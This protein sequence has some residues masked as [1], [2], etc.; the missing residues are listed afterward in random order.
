[1]KKIVLALILGFFLSWPNF[2]AARELKTI[3]MAELN[4]LLSESAGKVVML[5]FFATWCPPC[6]VEIPEVVASSKAYA[7]KKVVFVGLSVD[8]PKNKAT[9]EKFVDKM[10]IGYPVYMAGH[11]LIVRYNVGSIPHNIFYDP[12]GNLII[13]QPGEC[14]KEDIKLVVEELLHGD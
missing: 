11:D 12:K 7:G 5:N 1:M 3:N 14:D 8:E 2:L 10:Q 6:R 13:S 9:V 4:K